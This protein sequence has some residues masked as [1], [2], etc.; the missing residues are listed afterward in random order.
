[1]L[2][3]LAISNIQ[4]ESLWNKS[5]VYT[6]GERVEY[7]HGIYQAR[8][9]TRGNIP[10]SEPEWKFIECN[11]VSRTQPCEGDDLTGANVTDPDSTDPTVTTWRTGNVYLG[12]DQVIY[13]ASIFRAKWWT[14]GDKPSQMDPSGPW[15]FIKECLPFADTCDPGK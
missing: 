9:W 8:W 2:S 7:R 6:S 1:M 3:F 10:G 14:Q 15:T 5:T 12:G 11:D 13:S 4:A